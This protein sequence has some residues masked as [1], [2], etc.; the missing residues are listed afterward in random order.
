VG[1]RTIGVLNVSSDR[2]ADAFD[3][4]TLRIVERVCVEMAGVLLKALEITPRS[5]TPV[6]D[7]I[8]RQIDDAM[9]LESPL[10]T[11]LEGAAERLA[12]LVGATACRIHLADATGRRLERY[13]H[14]GAGA[15]NGPLS[16]PADA[17]ILGWLLAGRPETLVPAFTGEERRGIACF[18]VSGKLHVWASSSWRI[19]R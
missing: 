11:R 19:S 13:A 4:A 1:A 7:T 9:S 5:D 6:A 18:P 3:E 16:I 10:R 15:A 8:L 12:R 2:R 17:G 14:H